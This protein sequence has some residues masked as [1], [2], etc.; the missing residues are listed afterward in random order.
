E[1]GEK[2]RR[3]HVAP[4]VSG[5]LLAGNPHADRM[6]HRD[7][8]HF[9]SESV[10]DR[11]FQA[12]VPGG[13]LLARWLE[14]TTPAE[15]AR[16]AGEVKALLTSTKPPAGKEN[17]DAVL[18]RQARSMEGPLFGPLAASRTPR[19]ATDPGS[20]ASGKDWGLDPALF[21]KPIAGQAVDAESLGVMAPSVLEIR[22]PADLVAGREF[23]VTGELVP[24]A[25]AEGSVQLEL[26][27][28]PRSR[29]SLDRL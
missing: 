3:W 11:S 8:W 13:S 6:G 16:L 29:E 25:G 27:D 20:S 1:P 21:G 2:G 10:G 5:D 9:Y 18:Y 26:T 24:R 15:K 12:V 23:V 17:P 22:L 7:V 19:P 28:A 14:A 4:D